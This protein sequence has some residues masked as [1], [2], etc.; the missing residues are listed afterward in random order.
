M[1]RVGSTAKI[2][3]SFCNQC[4]REYTIDKF[5]ET[6]NPFHKNGVT[7]YCKDCCEEIVKYYLKQT[8]TLESAMWY[9]CSQIGIPFIKKVFDEFE[10]KISNYKSRS[11]KKDSE[12]NLFA[13]YYQSFSINRSRVDKWDDFMATDVSLGDIKSLRMSE[14]AL[15]L[16][17]DKYEFDWGKQETIEDYQFLEYSYKKNTEGIEFINNQ[18]EDLYR[19][20]CLARLQKRKLEEGRDTKGETMSQVQDRILKIMSKLRIDEF[21]S[22][23]AKTLSEQSLFEKIRLCD[24]NNVKDIYKEPK[25]FADHN[26]LLRYETDMVLRPLGNM[27]VGHRDFNI[28]INDIEDYKID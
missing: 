20:L 22:R 23:R 2:K 26:K 16:E 9:S 10:N 18:Q 24:E 17:Y 8:G 3:I 21:D 15:Q 28:N 25:K 6:T 1:P 27:L 19:D 13:N 14:E 12:Y 4:R 5:Y 11:G 7:L